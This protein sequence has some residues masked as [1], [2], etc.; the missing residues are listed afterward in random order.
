MIK[1]LRLTSETFSS[2]KTIII[3]KTN[4]INMSGWNS[5]TESNTC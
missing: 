5:K 1:Q 2:D 4:L 3:G